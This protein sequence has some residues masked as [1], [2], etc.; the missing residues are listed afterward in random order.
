MSKY[1]IY[2]IFLQVLCFSLLFAEVGNA[3]TESLKDIRLSVNW[4]NTKLKKVFSDL[5][6][7]TGFKFNFHDGEINANKNINVSITEA[8]M[9]DVLRTLSKKA[10]LKF[11]RVNGNI[12]VGKIE[13]YQEVITEYFSIQD[14]DISGKITD[15]NGE[16]LPGA[17]VVVK[18]TSSG[19]TTDV[20]GNYKL[21]AQESAILTISFVGYATQEILIGAKSVIDIQMQLDAEQL[22]EVVVVGYGSQK[23]VNL[24]GSVAMVDG[25]VLTKRPVTNAVSMLQGVLAGVNITAVNG[26]PREGGENI[27]IRGQGTFSSAG[28]APLVLIDGIPG[29]LYGINP[30]SIKSVSV[31]KDAASA[32]IYG[33]RGANGVILVTTKDGKSADGKISVGYDFNFSVQSP[34]SLPDLVT[35]SADF[36]RGWNTNVINSNYGTPR[37]ERMYPQSEIDKYEN[38]TDRHLYPN[39]DWFD[40]MID[41]APRT[42]HALSIKGGNKTRFNLTLGY[43]DEKGTLKSYGYKKFDTRLNITSEISKKF[44]TGAIL[45][46]KTGN[47]VGTPTWSSSN[48]DAENFYLTMFTQMPL[49]EPTVADGSP[50][51]TRS[52]YDFEGPNWN[53]YFQT[54][55]FDG[56]Y[57]KNWVG[58]GQLWS[59]FEIIKGLNWYTKA[60]FSGKFFDNKVHSGQPE[61]LRLYRDASALTVY[62]NPSYLIQEMTI[63][64]YKNFYSY[65]NYSKSIG[66]HELGLMVGTSYEDSHSNYI[67]AQRNQYTSNETTELDAGSSSSQI[68]SGNS[69]E[70]AIASLFG[71][72]NY[73]FKNKYLFEAN[74]RYD[75]TSRL[76]NE[77][78]WGVFPSFSAGWVLSEEAF[79]GESKLWLNFLKL[80]GSWGLLGNQNIGV[81]PYQAILSYTGSYP[82]DGSNSS[83]GVAQTSLN[84]NNLIWEKTTTTNLGLDVTFFDNLSLTIDAY[85]KY[86][87]DIL[88]S[89]QVNALVGLSAPVVNSGEMQNI[90][91]DLDLTY[92]GTVKSGSLENLRWNVGLIFN[93]FKNKLTKFGTPQLSGAYIREEGR[94]WNTFNLLQVEGIFQSMDEINSS[95]KQFGDN[96]QPGTLK[97]KDVNEDGIIDNNDRVPMEKGAFPDFTYGVRLG[98][99]WKNFDT[100][101]L[102]QGVQGSRMYA[103]GWGLQPYIQ[104]TAP[105]KKQLSQAWTPENQSTTEVML[106]DPLSYSKNSTY[107]LKDNSYLRLKTLQIGYTLPNTWLNKLGLQKMRIYFAGDNLLT[108]TKYEGSDPERSV[109]SGRY[110]SYPM[111]KVVSFGFN[112]IF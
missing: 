33:S 86:T 40:F 91:I 31:L 103:T 112:V 35:N 90:G 7:K 41:P 97:Y 34:T 67:S 14:V 63:D 15:E 89:A 11:R 36:M 13:E 84:N 62:K 16:G 25:E 22:E 51:F 21:K 9:E 5:N 48:I 54:K 32:S 77:K 81:Y 83:T 18:G 105:T 64:V 49:Y 19:T 102:F 78:R 75:G 94:P 72:V 1:A 6:K 39:F 108:S 99:E 23:K 27:A 17:S 92:S 66:E 3:Q 65:L 101:I 56:S 111:N 57:N 37:P 87:T 43:T 58:T 82:F 79:M 70:W 109:T 71:R 69:S 74:V 12:H 50:F 60:A 73:N 44:K 53:P 24:T 104:H 93:T 110:V 100:Y 106:G 45:N 98:A 76:S 2:G 8:S 95:P 29:S 88:R 80:R 68:N 59:N 4:E 26:Q 28:S 61:T 55:K 96:T 10:N 85:K 107:F 38:A 42:I 20:D 30:S 47:T 46:F 52:S